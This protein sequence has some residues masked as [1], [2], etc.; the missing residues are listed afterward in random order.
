MSARAF[1][2]LTD[3]AQPRLGGAVV[4]A[5]DDFFGDKSRLI[6]PSEPVFIPDKYDDH[7]KWMDGWESRRRRDSGHDYCIVKLGRPGKV[8]GFEIDTRHFTG[9]YPPAASIDACSCNLETPDESANWETLVERVA[10]KGDD[11]RF[12]EV[13]DDRVWTHVRLVIYPDGGVARLRVY[14][15]V[16]MDWNA[17]GADTLIDL[18]A[19]EFGGRTVACNDEHFGRLDNLIAPGRG[20]NMGDGWETRRRREP[21]HDWAVIELAHPGTIEQIVIDTAHFKGNYP[22]RCSIQATGAAPGGDEAIGAAA[23]TWPVLLPEQ[24]LDADR[25]HLFT[26]AIVAHKPVRYVRLNIYPDGGV[27]RLRLFGRI[28]AGAKDQG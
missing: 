17:V 2:R 11:R 24:K 23:E 5:T 16:H 4:F 25:E 26:E 13:D 1:T 6:A 15:R 20:V 22:D 8:A 18:A 14:G 3:L 19:M 10:L 12:I 21:G 28:A 27:S 7:G 9:N